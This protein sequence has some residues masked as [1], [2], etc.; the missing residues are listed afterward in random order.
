MKLRVLIIIIW[1]GIFILPIKADN[2]TPL[3]K[4]TDL[5]LDTSVITNTNYAYTQPK[6]ILF[7]P[8]FIT[9]LN[10]I[11]P[12]TWY[13]G[14]FYYL[15]SS[16]Y[17]FQDIP[18]HYIIDKNGQIYE[19]IDGGTERKITIG[20][21]TDAAIVVFYLADKGDVDINPN[22][23]KAV[24]DLLLNISNENAISPKNIS[25]SGLKLTIQQAQKQVLLSPDPIYG[26]W[27]LTFN[28]MLTSIGK[29]YNP[30]LKT[31]SI[32]IVSYNNPANKVLSE[33]EIVLQ[34]TI[35]NTGQ[36]TIF[37]NTGSELLL[38]TADGKDSN[39]F[40]NNV[41]LTK[42]QL[43]LM[44]TGS[45][46]LPN[47]QATYDFKVHTPFVFGNL[48]QDFIIRTADGQNFSGAK[49]SVSL[50]IDRN[51]IKLIQVGST[52]T[53]T[54][55]VHRDPTYSSPTIG[56]ASV[57]ERYQWVEKTAD[58]WYHI[59]FNSSLGWVLGKYVNEI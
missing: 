8:I 9:G 51:G 17:T 33:Q 38:S 20:T 21:N 41:W 53:G 35:K 49:F 16:R 50:N 3:I 22:A 32:Q 56:K 5:N 36:H 1:I 30:A 52:V 4:K 44:P 48:S 23:Q 24:Q 29:L 58:G 55:N 19:G 42:S 13:K 31:Y 57:G 26:N 45:I 6:S 27:K 15:S 37:Q 14:L 11:N 39:L 59:H 28:N 2:L 7:C 43:S 40:L 47:K 25:I 10:T 12:A 54:L 46:L 34:I 18:A